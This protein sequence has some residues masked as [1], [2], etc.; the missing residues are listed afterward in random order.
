MSCCIFGKYNSFIKKLLL[1]ILVLL[2]LWAM[3]QYGAPYDHY[4][5]QYATQGTDFWVCF[6]RTVDGM[7]GNKTKLYVV[8]ERECDVTISAPQLNWSK[9]AHIMPRVMCSPDSNYILIPESVCRFLDTVHY[10]THF[11]VHF[12]LLNG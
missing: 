2:P 9:T 6:P 11:I 10:P 5:E 3:P 8:S 7:N 1:H 4:G 12:C